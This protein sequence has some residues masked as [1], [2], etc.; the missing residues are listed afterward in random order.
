MLGT[1]KQE[2]MRTIDQCT[3][4]LVKQNTLF[5]N[6]FWKLLLWLERKQRPRT[7]YNPNSHSL[8]FF[9]KYTLQTQPLKTT[10]FPT[11]KLYK[12][13]LKKYFK[14]NTT[15]WL[16]R[17]QRCKAIYNPIMH[18]DQDREQITWRTNCEQKFNFQ[19]TLK[20]RVLFNTKK[21]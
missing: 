12:I 1:I 3:L 10:F 11:A 16:E 15:L 2:H 17:K 4:K 5:T 21:I 14:K 7:V 9:E 18:C 13:H 20:E 8:P 6:T 19:P